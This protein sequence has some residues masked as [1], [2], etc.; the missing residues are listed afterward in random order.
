[1][2]NYL[3]EVGACATD[4]PWQHCGCLIQLF[5]LFRCQPEIVPTFA[6]VD[7]PELKKICIQEEEK[8]KAALQAEQEKKEQALKEKKE[9]AAAANNAKAAENEEK[10]TEGDGKPS[11][12][13]TKPAENE[14]KPAENEAKPGEGEVA[15]EEAGQKEADENLP[16]AE[17]EIKVTEAPENDPQ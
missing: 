15:S 9:A 6:R 2:C 7:G 14:T 12:A 16:K 13:E 10:P 4:S 3:K 5:F 17:V 1:M 11:D 8:K